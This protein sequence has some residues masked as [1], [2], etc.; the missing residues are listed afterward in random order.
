[1]PR[2]RRSVSWPLFP[3]D[4]EDAKTLLKSSDKAMYRVKRAGKNGFGYFRSAD[5]PL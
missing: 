3:D 2:K 4:G 1:M 5:V